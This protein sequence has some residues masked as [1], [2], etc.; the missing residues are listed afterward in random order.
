[1]SVEASECKTI[2]MQNHLPPREA[3]LLALQNTSE[4]D[5]LVIGG[6]ATGS[7]CA[8]DAVTRGKC[9][10]SGHELYRMW[11]VLSLGVIVRTN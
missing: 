8:L 2:Q 3:Q 5:V 1:M 6:G 10:N 4:F 9:C 11:T 7:G